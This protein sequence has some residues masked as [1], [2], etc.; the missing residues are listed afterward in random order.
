MNIPI[1]LYAKAGWFG[2][3]QQAAN[4]EEFFE[5]WT[6][7]GDGTIVNNLTSVVVDPYG[8]TLEESEEHGYMR[9]IIACVN[10][11]AQ[12]PT[13]L[14]ESLSPLDVERF[15]KFAMLEHGVP[16]LAPDANGGAK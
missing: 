1:D 6:L 9:R 16:R 10:A 15:L 8:S 7:D 2:V 11:C 13:E 4:L 12:L 14:L 3:D 5:P